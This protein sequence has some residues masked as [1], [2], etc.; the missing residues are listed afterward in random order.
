[1][2]AKPNNFQVGYDV[3]HDKAQNVKSGWLL[4]ICSADFPL[5]PFDDKVWS[6]VLAELLRRQDW[7]AVYGILR[8]CLSTTPLK[9]LDQNRS[10]AVLD[11]FSLPEMPLPSKWALELLVL[12]AINQGTKSL[13]F[14]H[15]IILSFC[16]PVILSFCRLHAM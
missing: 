13:S 14:C 6:G 8:A 4:F 3:F 1:M 10:S 12:W 11:F 7:A 2:Q 5:E 16:H 15:S 9:V